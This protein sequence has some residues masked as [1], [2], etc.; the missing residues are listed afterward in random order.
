MAKK[1]KVY[2]IKLTYEMSIACALPSLGSPN[3]NHILN[4]YQWGEF[5]S[6]YFL[7]FGMCHTYLIL[8]VK[9]RYHHFFFLN[10]I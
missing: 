9:V 6:I 2:A 3:M 1:K 8:T 5:Y 7:F 10:N 4:H